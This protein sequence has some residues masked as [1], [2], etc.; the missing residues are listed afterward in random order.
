MIGSTKMTQEIRPNGKI[1]ESVCTSLG[2]GWVIVVVVIVIVG[3]GSGVVLWQMM[4]MM[5]GQWREY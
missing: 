1:I 2:S 5:S 3:G 4:T